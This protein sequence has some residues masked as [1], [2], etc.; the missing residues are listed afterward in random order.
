MSQL[1][2]GL[3]YKFGCLMPIKIVGSHLTTTQLESLNEI[4]A[5]LCEK[6]L[7]GHT[8][9]VF[10][11]I[12]AVDKSS[13]ALN[14][15]EL[16][17]TGRLIQFKTIYFDAVHKGKI[18]HYWRILADAAVDDGCDFFVLLGDDVIIHTEAW[19]DCIVQEFENFHRQSSLPSS[20][21]GFGCLALNDLQAPGFP[22][23]P[24]LHKLH[25]AL[26][27]ELFSDVFINQD[28]DPFLFQLYRRFGAASFS[29]T[30]DITNS[31]GGVQLSD[32]IHFV[33]PRY[34]RLHLD[35]WSGALLDDSIKKI[36]H[37]ISGKC[38]LSSLGMY[39]LEVLTVDV[40]IPSYRVDRSFLSRIFDLKCKSKNISL[41]FI[42]IIDDPNAD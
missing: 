21:F 34:T 16:I 37:N 32:D 35:K 2:Y 40:V 39:D 28:A 29:S 26:H 24:V 41:F 7:Y 25:Y 4:A 33:E 42:V 11:G 20:M 13:S 8:V 15:I 36:S 9:K 30:V 12:D 27:A 14:E 3:P 38:N 18:C 23:F 10:L 1:I 17:F 5:K 6:S 22:T 31:V 19:I